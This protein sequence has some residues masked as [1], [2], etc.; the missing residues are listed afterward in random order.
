MR[1]ENDEEV[2][3]I[4]SKY[5]EIIQIINRN[6]GTKVTFLETPVY[7]IENWN[8]LKGHK[9]TN[10]VVEQD[11]NLPKQIYTFNDKVREINNSICTHSPECS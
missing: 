1:S 2:D 5:N 10:V 3:N 8:E 11:E 6:P 4:I 7:S 9:D